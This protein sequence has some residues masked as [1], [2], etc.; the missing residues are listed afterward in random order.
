M[1]LSRLL[2][3]LGNGFKQTKKKLRVLKKQPMLN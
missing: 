1:T 2:K 3:L